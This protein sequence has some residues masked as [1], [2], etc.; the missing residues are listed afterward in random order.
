[1]MVIARG[2]FVLFLGGSLSL[3]SHLQVAGIL[4]R[5]PLRSLVIL[6]FFLTCSSSFPQQSQL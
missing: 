3:S 6:I 4:Y 5:R 1:M 2:V